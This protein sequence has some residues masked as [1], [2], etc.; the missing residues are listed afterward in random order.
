M[1]HHVQAVRDEQVREAQA[2]LQVLQEVEHLRLHRHVERRYRLVADD[3]LGLG[4]ERTG[5]PDALALAARELVRIAGRH[6]RGEPHELQQL[7]HAPGNLVRRKQAVR[8]DGLGDDL[9][10]GHARVE[11][12]V[13]VLE[14]E[15]DITAEGA[16]L[17]RGERGDVTAVEGDGAA[18]GRDQSG[19]HA[20][21]RRLAAT[22]L[23]HEPEHLAAA[24]GERDV[25]D[26]AH[27]REGL[28]EHARLGYERLGEVLDAQ[29]HVV[30]GGGS[31]L[32]IYH[33]C[34]SRG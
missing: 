14:H 33:Q 28:T 23:A 10:D 27:V 6:G 18:R 9:G 30:A 22:G 19:D 2:L 25:V 8:H 15:L 1:L 4:G 17:A 7:R 24:D 20:A 13:R 21:N 26:G 3:E 12:G 16:P 31:V 32:D 5:D 11:R 34:T 29:Q